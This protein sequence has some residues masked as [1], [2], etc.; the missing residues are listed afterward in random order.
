MTERRM[1]PS[2]PEYK[3]RNFLQT[4]LMIAKNPHMHFL[5][6]GIGDTP[7]DQA[8][9]RFEDEIAAQDLSSKVEKA[10]GRVDNDTSGV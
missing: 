1:M 8:K 5:G 2:D 6:F 4:L 3:G 7:I 10:M 9:Q